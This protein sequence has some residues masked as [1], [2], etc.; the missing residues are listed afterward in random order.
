MYQILPQPCVEQ[1]RGVLLTS[2][3][4]FILNLVETFVTIGLLIFAKYHENWHIKIA[5]L[6]GTIGVKLF[7][8][9]FNFVVAIVCMLSKSCGFFYSIQLHEY[10][11]E[12]VP[13]P[14]GDPVHST[15]LPAVRAEDIG[16]AIIDGF[17]YYDV[18]IIGVC[19]V[20]GSVGIAIGA[21]ILLV[22][23]NDIKMYVLWRLGK[24]DQ[25]IDD[26]YN[27]ND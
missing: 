23:R 19:L 4:V 9:A 5:V 11:D 24:L 12:G 8:T 13:E 10:D 18:K 6:V 3:A 25:Y 20:L 15:P 21:M 1:N 27:H 14:D 2:V 16:S 26:T 17:R 7:L 22:K